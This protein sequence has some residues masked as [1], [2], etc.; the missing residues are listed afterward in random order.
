MNRHQNHTR[1]L[2]PATAS[3]L[4]FVAGIIFIVLSFTLLPI[5]GLVVALLLMLTAIGLVG[6]ARKEMAYE[7]IKRR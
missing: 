2:S 5:I 4:F 3:I 6:K 7:K 1:R